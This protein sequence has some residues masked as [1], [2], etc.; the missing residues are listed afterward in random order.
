MSKRSSL[1]E[2]GPGTGRVCEKLCALQRGELKLKV[3]SATEEEDAKGSK[4]SG[5]RRKEKREGGGVSGAGVEV[6]RDIKSK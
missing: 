5:G 1:I 4:K 2:P 3:S 6:L